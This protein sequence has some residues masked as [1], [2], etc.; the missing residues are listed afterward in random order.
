MQTLRCFGYENRH[1]ML[2]DGVDKRLEIIMQEV[3]TENGSER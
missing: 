1:A 2:V 3:A